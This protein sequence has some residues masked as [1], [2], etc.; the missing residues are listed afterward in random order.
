MRLSAVWRVAL[1]S[2]GIVA[3][4]SAQRGAAPVSRGVILGA[5]TDT[6]LRAVAGVNVEVIGTT[7]RLTTGEDGLFRVHD[8]SAGEYLVWIRRLGFRPVSH[9]VRVEPGD[10]LRLAYTI[11]PTLTELSTVV[12]TAKSLSPRMRDFEARRKFGF[13]QFMTQAEIEKLNFVRLDGYLHTFSAVRLEPNRGS[14][15]NTVTSRRVARCPMTVLVDGLPRG[16]N[17]DDLPAPRE[18]AGIEVYAGPASAPLEFG[19]ASCGII[20]IW[21]R[22]GR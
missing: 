12:V 16:S 22:D 18:I 17:T 14:A 21:T 9:V 8:V 13:G 3:P 2:L 5:V 11:E 19:K 15:G 20:L 6:S 10:T 1:L 4:A 7:A